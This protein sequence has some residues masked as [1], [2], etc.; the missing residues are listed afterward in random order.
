MHGR[1]AGFRRHGL[2]TSRY[3]NRTTVRRSPA[4]A[5]MTSACMSLR[6]AYFLAC[7]RTRF[8]V[9]VHF[10]FTSSLLSCVQSHL[11]KPWGPPEQEPSRPGSLHRQRTLLSLKAR[12]ILQRLC[13]PDTQPNVTAT[14]YRVM[15]ADVDSRC[16]YLRDYIVSF[17]GSNASMYNNAVLFAGLLCQRRGWHPCSGPTPGITGATPALACRGVRESSV[18]ICAWHSTFSHPGHPEGHGSISAITAA[19]HGATV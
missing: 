12:S 18:R 10:G 6:M 3:K 1:F 5:L 14:E 15:W 16:P 8:V 2:T 19:A 17:R 9:Y 4:N 7:E 13:T 11:V